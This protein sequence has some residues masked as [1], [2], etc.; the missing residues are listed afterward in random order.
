MA[1]RSSVPA[2]DRAPQAAA[3]RGLGVR[4][5]SACPR[6]SRAGGGRGAEVAEKERP[7]ARAPWRTVGPLA[8]GAAFSE[9]LLCAQPRLFLTT[10]AGRRP[11]TVPFSGEGPRSEAQKD[12]PGPHQGRARAWNYGTR[13]PS[14]DRWVSPFADCSARF[15]PSPLFFSMTSFTKSS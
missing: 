2:A 1:P 3:P 13:P 4:S 15:P 8:S 12:A 14:P 7:G 9:R 10:T 5:G 11:P 6:Q